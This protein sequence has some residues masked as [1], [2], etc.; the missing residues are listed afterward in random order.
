MSIAG[1]NGNEFIVLAI[2]A[3][4]LLGPEKLP[5]YARKLATLIRDLRRLASGAQEQLREE[6]GE[7]FADMDLKKFD[8]RQ[9]DPRRIISEALRDQLEEPPAQGF[10]DSARS[11]G[12]ETRNSSSPPEPSGPAPFDD[13]ST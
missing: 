11:R 3:A 8:P 10:P 9:Y 1:I 5:D 6:L 4:V 7:D 13:E 12:P 2:L